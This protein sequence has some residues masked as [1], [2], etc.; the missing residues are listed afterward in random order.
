M[1]RG[2]QGSEEQAL[3]YFSILASAQRGRQASGPDRSPEHGGLLLLLPSQ[4]Q[5]RT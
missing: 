1:E 2:P 4:T 3:V 5:E